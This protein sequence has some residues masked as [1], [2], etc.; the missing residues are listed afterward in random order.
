MKT[1]KFDELRKRMV[2]EQL[3]ARGIKDKKV[4][5]IFSQVPRHKFI[6]EE[7]WTSAYQDHPLPIGHGQTI[8][9]P[10]MVALMTQS[11]LLKGGEKVLEIGTGSGYQ[12]AILAKIAK[13]VYSV[14]KPFLP[15]LSGGILKLVIILENTFFSILI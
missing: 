15:F 13:Q 11:L 6:G 14:V 8:S 9:Q 12:A 5:E 2:Q 7:L 4:L 10:Y 3:V 1:L